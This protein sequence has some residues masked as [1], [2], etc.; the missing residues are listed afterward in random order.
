[1]DDP[2]FQR[3]ASRSCLVPGMEMIGWSRQTNSRRGFRAH[4]HPVCF[5]I[6]LIRKGSVDWWTEDQTYVVNDRNVYI[7]YPG[8][9][10]GTVGTVL[11]PCD[12]YWFQLRWTRREPPSF[13]TAREGAALYRKLHDLPSRVFRVSD[14]VVDLFEQLLE[15]HRD[16]REESPI[17]CHG[18]V[19]QLL[20]LLIIEGCGGAKTV[21]SAVG[22]AMQWMR[23]HSDDEYSLADVADTAGLSVSRLQARFRSEA[24]CALGEFRARLRLSKA[25]RL[26]S[27]TGLSV[28]D[29]AMQLG[30]ST[31]QYFATMFRKHSGMSP[32]EYR[33]TMRSSP[34]AH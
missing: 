20:A 21:S 8:E 3:Y 12:L 25:R 6:C 14:R 31:S 4:D 32:R 19:V 1:M 30:F 23:E 26:L 28:T 10:H 13:L 34:N 16:Q 11:Q 15:E 17:V 22:R 27:T 2:N 7:S 5:E 24:G 33:A 18:I 29:I 9:M